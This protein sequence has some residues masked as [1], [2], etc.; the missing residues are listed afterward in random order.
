MQVLDN[1]KPPRAKRLKMEKAGRTIN[2]TLISRN[3][4]VNGHRTSVRLEPDMWR[5]LIE[6][7]KREKS[8]QHEICSLIA[9][10]KPKETSLTAALRVFIMAYFR[11]AATEDGHNRAGHG[12]GLI[13]NT[14]ENITRVPVAI[15][16]ASGNGMARVVASMPYMMGAPVKPNI[17]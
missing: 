11:A 12:Q 14:I 4:T 17:R 10:S 16:A 8:N 1:A 9:V 13:G 6:I 5:G 7:C 15:A 2:S 3:V